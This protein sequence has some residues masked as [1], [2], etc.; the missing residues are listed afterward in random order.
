MKEIYEAYILVAKTSKELDH[1]GD[2]GVEKNNI[3]NRLWGP[4]KLL[5]NGYRGLFPRG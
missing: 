3:K 5:S 1:L 2:I 4:P